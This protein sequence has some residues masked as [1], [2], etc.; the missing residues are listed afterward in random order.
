MSDALPVSVVVPTIG[1][2]AQLRACLESLA[3]CEPRAAEVVVVDQ[4]TT[5]ETAAL[6]EQF[7]RIGARRAH[8]DGRGVGLARNTGLREAN[9]DVV[10]MT[11]D[12]CTVAPTWVATAHRLASAD[13]GRIFTG[14][15]LEGKNEGG[16]G[17]TPST[18]TDE[19]AHDFTGEL[20]CDGLFSG[21]VVLPRRAAL[22]LGGFDERLETAEDNDFGYR[23]LRAG[24][25]MTFDPELV[26]WH[27][28]WRTPQELERLYVVYWRGQGAFYGKHLRSRDPMMLRFL[29]RDLKKAVKATGERVLRGRP[30]WTDWRRGIMRGLP[31]GLWR[32]LLG[33]PSR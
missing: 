9:H 19:V 33:R 3:R 20:S 11:D 12:D 30:R 27:N 32:G 6:V 23:W 7:G 16:G 13:P 18:R 29:A 2:P 24:R 5:R 22:E 10:A 28:D 14:R 25:P 17:Y 31:V 1:R 4:S 8:S 21:N 15:V 26:V